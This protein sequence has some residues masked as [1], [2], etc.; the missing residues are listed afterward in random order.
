M[1][2]KI[3]PTGFIITFIGAVL[4]STKAVIVKKAFHDT[5]ID[6]LS[7]L[8]IRMIFS[9]PFYLGIA[10][11]AGNKKSN[12]NFTKQQWCWIITLGL[13]GYYISSFL[14]FAGLQYVSA[15]LERLILFLYPTFAVL[16]NATVF[17]QKI[18]CIQL[19]ALVLT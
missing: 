4:F 13:F 17:K 1:N 2:K 10:I 5:H 16:I 11:F 19:L 18:S 3:S 8:T 12:I 6:A 14:D 9:L 15:G 7:L